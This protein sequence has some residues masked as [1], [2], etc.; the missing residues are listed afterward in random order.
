MRKLSSLSALVCFLLAI[1]A[2]MAATPA[3]SQKEGTN[4]AQKAQNYVQLP[5]TRAVL[6]LTANSQIAQPNQSVHFMLVWNRP[7]YRLTYHFDWGD[8]T[9]SDGTDT[10]ADHSYSSPGNYIVRVTARPIA[11]VKMATRLPDISVPSNAVA[12]VV[13]LPAQP[14]V[15]LTADKMNLSVDETVR[16]LATPNPPT[17]DAQ[18]H[19]DFG[20]GSG[21]NSAS[22]Q[23]GHTYSGANTY[24]AKVTALTQNR[25][26]AATSPPIE[27]T[28]AAAPKPPP[29]LIV[30]RANNAMLITGNDIVV[31]ASL[32]P[33]QKNATFEFDWGDGSAAEKVGSQG[34]SD[35]HYA[36]PGLHDVV[37]TAVTEEAYLPPLQ[38]M[39]RLSIEAPVPPPPPMWP[40][41]AAWAAAVGMVG[42]I[43]WL[44]F[45]VQASPPHNPPVPRSEETKPKATQQKFRYVAYE[46]STKHEMKMGRRSR[47]LGSMTLSSGM[48]RAEHTIKF[49]G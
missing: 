36:T 45:R 35:H 49:L 3:A 48:D 47:S 38:G 19:F 39:L 20:D 31:E 7:V 46:G 14:T 8:G 43:F 9:S 21:Q 5:A 1:S 27:I 10:A 24:Q 37:V 22:N 18:Y 44:I 34:L 40:R 23:I 4:L 25:R 32:H 6:T 28:V 29:K 42:F 16:F 33:P 17:P 15:T 41:I 26:Q 12:I 2:M 30:T 11:A 13:V